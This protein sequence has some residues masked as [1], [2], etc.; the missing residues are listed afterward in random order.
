MDAKD[1]LISFY[2]GS[3]RETVRNPDAP[4]W[5]PAPAP[6]KGPNPERGRTVYGTCPV[7]GGTGTTKRE[8]ARLFAVGGWDVFREMT[9]NDYSAGVD[10]TADRTVF[11]VIR[12]GVV[13][14]VREVLHRV[15]GPPKDLFSRD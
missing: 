13:V 7:C 11:V 8:I 5:C 10:Q 9:D 2:D 4:T 1:L 6:H 15:L 3:F 12:N 14:S